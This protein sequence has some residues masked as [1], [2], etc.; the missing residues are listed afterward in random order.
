MPCWV[1]MVPGKYARKDTCGR[2]VGDAGNCMSMENRC[3][4]IPQRM[5]WQPEF[6]STVFQDPSLIP[7]LTIEQN[8]RLSNIE[9]SKFR[10]WL[11]WFNLGTLD[12]SALVRELPLET[13]RIADLAR[14]LPVNHNYYYSMN[15]Q[16]L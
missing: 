5:P 6:L 9:E 12:L 8:L 14:L 2:T 3:L 15:L 1:R 13:L 16:R 7:D 11:E 10:E 4:F